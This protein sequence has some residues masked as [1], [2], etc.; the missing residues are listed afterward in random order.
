MD[1]TPHTEAEVAEMLRAIG[2]SSIDELFRAIPETF[3]VEGGLKLPDG[4]SE[5]AVL[6]RMNALAMKNVPVTCAT[7]FLGAGAYDHYVPSAVHHLTGRGEF[8]TVYT[9]YQPELSQGTLQAQFE[10]QTMVAGILGMDVA[11]ASMYE[12]A[13]GLAEACLMATRHARRPK[14]LVSRGVHPQYREVVRTYLGADRVVEAPLDPVTG[15]TARVDVGSDIAAVVIQSPNFLGVVEDQQAFS[16]AAHAAGALSIATFTEAL[17]F[18]LIEAPGNLGADLATGEGQSLGLPLSFGGPYIGFFAVKQPFVKVMPGRLIGRT[19]DAHGNPCY[20]LTLAARE[21]HIRRE[22]ASSNIC[23]NEGLCALAV[24]IHLSLLGKAGYAKLARYNHL[25]AEALKKRLADKGY[26]PAFTGPTFNE[27]AVRV[28]GR[29]ADLVERLAA[30]YVVP[31]YDLGQEDP[32]WGSL[33]L[34]NVTEQR[35]DAD[36]DRLLA[37]L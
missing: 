16:D 8:L 36:F 29:A 11:N 10:Y 19:R 21:Q 25:R 32:A 31:G 4:M 22:R 1:F 33:L 9:P 35:S 17:A 28:P 2:V 3:A 20:A 23:S 26:A 18:G 7:S 15:A 24:A 30:S 27:F 34:V 5:A 37:A 13:T 12:G 6:A 14:V